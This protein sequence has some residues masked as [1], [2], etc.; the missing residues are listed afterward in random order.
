ML[1]HLNN[2]INRSTD[3]KPFDIPI[4]FTLPVRKPLPKGEFSDIITSYN[5]LKAEKNSKK[6]DSKSVVN[7]S[8][9]IVSHALSRTKVPPPNDDSFVANKM[10]SKEA[11][12]TFNELQA[13]LERKELI[14]KLDA[15]QRSILEQLRK[16]EDEKH[17]DIMEEDTTSLDEIIDLVEKKHSSTGCVSTVMKELSKDVNFLTYPEKIRIPRGKFKRGCTY[18]LNDCYYDESG[19]FL[20][21]VPGMEQ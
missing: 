13:T 6:A 18:K 16:D 12:V 21:R 2:F 1:S 8:K 15:Y 11:D 10:K 20:Y 5:K 17:V 14:G 9:T 4:D 7:E 3:H 19:L